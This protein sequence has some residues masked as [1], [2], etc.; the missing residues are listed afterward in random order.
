MT[1]LI[2][3]LAALQT[4]EGYERK[5]VYH[6]PQSPGYTSW[7]GTARLA[8]GSLV[9]GFTQATGPLDPALRERAPRD[10]TDRLGVTALIQSQPSYDFWGLSLSAIYRR[11]TD[12]GATWQ[13]LHEHAFKAVFPHPYAAQ[14]LF[15][16]ADGSLLRRVNGW[17]LLH[18]PAVPHTAYLQR[19]A[20]GATAWSAPQV[21][22]DPATRTY[23]LSRLRRLR[24]G[25]LLATGQVWDVPAGTAHAEM[26]RAPARHLLAVSADE[27]RTWTST[28]VAIPAGAYVGVNEWDAAELPG[29]DLLAVFRTRRAADDGTAVRRQGILKQDGGSWTLVEVTDPP[30]PHSGHPELLATREGPILHVATTGVHWTSDAGRTWTALSFP[31]ISGGYRSPYYPVSLLDPDGTIRVLGH[32]GADDWYGRRDQSVLMDT[33]VLSGFTSAPPPAP[34]QSEGREG[35]NGDGSLNDS[36][37]GA[38][39][40]EA[41]IVLAALRGLRR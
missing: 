16:L 33:F 20:P 2:L 18:D 4:A 22:L 36:L 5:T 13:P 31:Q 23:Q 30:F 21:L 17:D 38:L 25:R 37:C 7:V 40:I 28:A 11:S 26:S 24:D 1:T 9:A 27:G 14:G 32:V 6:S 34:E 3:A 39:G 15:V 29:G 41:L 10:L 12:G 35:E 8:D 19:L